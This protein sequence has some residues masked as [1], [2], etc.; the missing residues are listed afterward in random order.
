MSIKNSKTHKTSYKTF[1]SGLYIETYFTKVYYL[2]DKIRK[3]KEYHLVEY[4]Q[5]LFRA[6]YGDNFVDVNDDDYDQEL[7]SYF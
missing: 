2:M 4:N 5:D 7:D 6:C 3:D 1:N